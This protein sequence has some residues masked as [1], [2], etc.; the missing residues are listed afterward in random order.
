M[1]KAVPKSIYRARL[2]QTLIKRHYRTKSLPGPVPNTT[3]NLLKTMLTRYQIA[4]LVKNIPSELLLEA[5]PKSHQIMTVLKWSSK[6]CGTNMLP[7]LVPKKPTK[8]QQNEMLVHNSLNKKSVQNTAK[9][10]FSKKCFFG[11]SSLKEYSRK[12]LAKLPMQLGYGKRPVSES[13]WNSSR[14]KMLLY[15]GVEK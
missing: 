13:S 5:V 3:I 8:K 14:K 1:A 7:E 9:K 15:F 10:S 12:M 11:K 2:C 4:M 6:K